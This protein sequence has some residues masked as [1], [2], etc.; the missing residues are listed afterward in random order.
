MIIYKIQPL[1]L[2]ERLELRKYGNDKFGANR[3][4]VVSN[5][6]NPAKAAAETMAVKH[7]LKNYKAAW[8][9]EKKMWWWNDKFRNEE[10]LVRIAAQAA[11]EANDFLA[12]QGGQTP[13]AQEPQADNPEGQPQGQAQHPKLAEVLK[14]LQDIQDLVEKSQVS[15]EAT[16]H[17]KEDVKQLLEKFV[18]ELASAVD[19]VAL[20]EKLAEYFNWIAQF[21]QYSF[22]NKILIYL[23]RMNAKRVNSKTGWGKLG[24]FPK[25][26]AQQIMVWRPTLKE[27]N[28]ATQEKRKATYIG[29]IGQP[30]SEAQQKEMMK[31][32]MEPVASM[33]FILYPV[34]DITDVTNEEGGQ[35]EAPQQ[36]DLDWEGDHEQDT[37]ELDRLYEAII[38]SIQQLGIKLEF[39]DD[40]GGAKGSSAGG[41]IKL[42]RNRTGVQKVKTAIHELGHELM[43]HKYLR[44]KAEADS[45]PDAVH[46]KND[47]INAYVGR[48]AREVLELQAEGVAYVVMRSFGYNEKYSINYIALWKGTKES[49]L[50]NLTIITNTANVII[51]TMNGHLEG[52]PTNYRDDSEADAAAGADMI[53]GKQVAETE[54]AAIK[55]GETVSRAEVAQLLK[56]D[57]DSMTSLNES[58]DHILSRKNILKDII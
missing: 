52:K 38:A 16:Q 33:P 35:P 30:K 18:H 41:V 51:N 26:D 47:I 28:K 58:I 42:L 55:H 7:I 39:E 5:E 31:F 50:A 20:S 44:A 2:L 56:L 22:F 32:M 11:D 3:V 23:Q 10:E 34:Y 57:L 24:F 17:S 43:H 49:I 15:P 13:A 53:G 27:P 37:P 8:D 46:K 21:P 25:E 36:A 29:K 45:N 12:K 40:M 19:D 48:D 14:T 6:K 1:N 54:E 9:G 4:V